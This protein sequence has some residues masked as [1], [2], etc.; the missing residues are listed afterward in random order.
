MSVSSL[1]LHTV[2]CHVEPR[3]STDDVVFTVALF[4]LSVGAS[5]CY[6]FEVGVLGCLGSFAG[7]FC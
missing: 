1:N 3:V 2:G 5:R 6:D 4:G 7:R